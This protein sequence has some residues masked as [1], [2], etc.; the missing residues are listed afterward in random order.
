MW[1]VTFEVQTHVGR[2]RRLGAVLQDYLVDLNFAC[3]Y[4]LLAQGTKN[5]FA[6]AIRSSVGQRP[7]FSLPV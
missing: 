4:T 5:D 3:A 2:F 6:P 1:L 7:A